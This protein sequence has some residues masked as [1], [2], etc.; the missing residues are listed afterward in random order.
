MN[1]KILIYKEEHKLKP[2]GGPVGYLYNLRQEL[3][4]KKNSN[5]DF[6]TCENSSF[7]QERIKKIIPKRMKNLIAGIYRR[8]LFGRLLSNAP[9][10][11]S[12]DLSGYDIVHFHSTLDMYKVKDSLESYS[13]IVVLTTH[14]PKAPHLEII[15]DSMKNWERMI[16]KKLYSKLERIDT[17]AFDKANYIVF[18]CKEAEEPYYNTWKGYR[19]I[20]NKNKHKYK[21]LF[22]GINSAK[23]KLTKQQI[24]DKYN[25]PK[26]SFI[27]SYVGRHIETKGFDDLKRIGEYLLNKKN[28]IYFLVAGKEEPIKGLKDERW[29]EIGWTDDP[30]SIIAAADVFV[31]PNKETYFDLIMLEVLS[32]GKVIV[33]SYT[34]GNKV[35][36]R[37]GENGV[38]TYKSLDEA[39]QILLNLSESSQRKIEEMGNYNKELFNQ[40]FTAKKFCNGYIKLMDEILQDNNS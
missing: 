12:V 38:R 7:K 4:N 32:L 14:C 3:G 16:F 20:K 34:G 19:L 26:D 23:P 2:I 22:T 24:Y 28:N 30:H 21:Y 10:I 40:E 15:E 11:S 8:Q 31:L 37:L 35:F 39:S 18:P 36:E 29:I 1:K 6:I 27:I 13:G 25:I 9:K 17:Y 5:I 33:A